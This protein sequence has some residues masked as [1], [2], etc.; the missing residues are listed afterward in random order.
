MADHMTRPRRVQ[1]RRDRP[2]RADHPDAVIVVRPSRWGNPYRADGKDPFRPGW[3][4]QARAVELYRWG[5]ENRCVTAPYTRFVDSQGREWF[6]G[7]A[8]IDV[9]PQYLRGRDLACWCRPCER[10]ADGLP[11][12]ET[13]PD[14]AP[15]HADVL[16]EIANGEAGW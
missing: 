16:L 3:I 4:D 10:H 5:V 1:M 11:L 12:G 8:V 2:W 14:C 15:C 9:A 7:N 6:G 13:C